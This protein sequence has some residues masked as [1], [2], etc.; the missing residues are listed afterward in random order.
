M[1]LQPVSS[2][3]SRLLAPG[4]NQEYT[5]VPFPALPGGPSVLR[6]SPL[7]WGPYPYPYPYPYP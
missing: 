6:V 7:S 3:H 2:I 5:C 1:I 4:E